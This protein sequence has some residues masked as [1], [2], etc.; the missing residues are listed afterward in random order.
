MDLDTR[1]LRALVAVADHGSF[2]GA[3]VDLGLSQAS[4]SRS[5]QRL[6]AALG[7]ALL[8]RTSR[9]VEVTP[10]GER[11]I[12]QAR[13]ILAGVADLEAV[14]ARPAAELRVGYAWAALGAHTIAVQ[15]AWEDVA[16]GV[17]VPDLV[18]V[19]TNSPTAGLVEGR[20]AVS[21]VRRPVDDDRLEAV[22]V[23]AEQR[24][25][26][27]AADEPLAVRSSVQLS[28]LAGRD[29]AVDPRSGTTRED[30]WPPDAP[31]VRLRSVSGVDDYLTLNA[32]GRAVGV[33]SEATVAQHPRPGIAY[34]PVRDAPAV[35]VW[36][37]WWRDDPPPGLDRL[38]ALTRTAYRAR[39]AR[40]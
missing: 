18:F 31:P 17:E 6:E 23:G 9:H 27:L 14:A 15:R 29:V 21:V 22:R 16:D 26:V 24:Y 40:Q 33:S 3:A 20:C 37:A 30:L 11:V 35:D 36:L 1:H 12:G 7:L 34:R 8:T 4:V 10:S 39:P 19:Q 2:T 38:V 5:V 32:S 25:A 28:D 13:R